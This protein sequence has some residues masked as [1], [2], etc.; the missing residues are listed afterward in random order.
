M[1]SIFQSSK[2]KCICSSLF[3]HM[4]FS[5]EKGIM[6]LL[7]HNFGLQGIILISA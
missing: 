1:S 4:M 3:G 7:C 5:I 2:S 6:C